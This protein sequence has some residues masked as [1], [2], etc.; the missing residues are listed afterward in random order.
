MEE[1]L[2]GV[3]TIM[4]KD[5]PSYPFQFKFVDDQFN[6]M[7][8]GEI[9]MSKISSVFAVLAILIS[10]FGLFGLATYSAERRIKEVGVRKVLGSSVSEIVGLLA[11]DFL[12]LVIISC[13]IAFPVAW[14]RMH[15]WLQGYNYRV[16]INWWV[17]LLSGLA[18]IF[19]AFVTISFQ[20]IKAATANPVKSLRTE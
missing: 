8:S 6:E 20:C 9:L 11:K 1:F 7:F 13:L 19:I 2:A 17:F 18:A 14:W 16:Q 10:C 3:Q 12:K 4:K 15:D 5:N